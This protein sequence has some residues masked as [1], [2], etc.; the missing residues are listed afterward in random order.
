MKQ[1]L[2]RERKEKI[3]ECVRV[4]TARWLQLFFKILCKCMPRDVDAGWTHQPYNCTWTGTAPWVAR[5]Y[6]MY[7][8]AAH[9]TILL[10]PLWQ[11]LEKYNCG[12]RIPVCLCASRYN[13]V[14]GNWSRWFHSTYC[15]I[16]VVEWCTAW[17]FE[18]PVNDPVSWTSC[19]K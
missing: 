18:A 15:R 13:G 6:H 19:S 10:Y 2:F 9:G 12:T 17:I 1:N 3:V 11:G 16:A 8:Y 5:M 4:E 7:A 14:L